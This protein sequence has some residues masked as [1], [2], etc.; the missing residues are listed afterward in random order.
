MK[1]CALFMVFINSPSYF[2]VK[3]VC[4][5]C[6][7]IILINLMVGDWEG[8]GGNADNVHLS[9]CLRKAVDLNIRTRHSSSACAHIVCFFTILP[10]LFRSRVVTAKV[11]YSCGRAAMEAGST[12]AVRVTATQIA[13]T[14]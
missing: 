13:F 12:T 11:Q 8:K 1:N 2:N 5:H 3:L 4:I 10:I 9:G 14:R 6:I 7:G